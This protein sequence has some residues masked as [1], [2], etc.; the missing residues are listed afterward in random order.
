LARQSRPT[1]AQ[2]GIAHVEPYTDA[3]S[4]LESLDVRLEYALAELTAVSAS[5][6]HERLRQYLLEA[7]ILRCSL[8]HVA[9][10]NAENAC[11]L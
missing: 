6:E 9:T 5:S 1:S 11:M 7:A 8:L 4:D 3:E 10:Q 2:L